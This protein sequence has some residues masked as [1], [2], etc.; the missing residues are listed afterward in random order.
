MY[1]T[2][3]DELKNYYKI[4]ADITANETSSKRVYTAVSENSYNP[5]I[6]K[7]IDKK[8]AQIYQ[9]IKTH[10]HR[11]I[12]NVYSVMECE[13]DNIYIAL[14][15]A[16]IN[17]DIKGSA[18]LTNYIKQHGIMDSETAIRLSLMLCEALSHIHSLGFIHRD[19]K[20]DNIMLQKHS[21][22]SMSVKLIDFGVSHEKEDISSC[23]KPKTSIEDAGT[24]GYNPYDKKIT[25]RFDVF[26]LGC[27][28]NYMLTGHTPDFE[29]YSKDIKLRS[30]IEMSTRDYFIRIKNPE[31]MYHYLKHGYTGLSLISHFGFF[32]AM[33]IYFALAITLILKQL[34]TNAPLSI[35]LTL[36]MCWC[37][38]PVLMLFDP[39]SLRFRIRILHRLTSNNPLFFIILKTIITTVS[40]FIPFIFYIL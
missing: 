1:P 31:D 17:D 22:G 13:K 10:P 37:I 25:P 16:I 23:S 19:L 39:F 12:A 38:I 18:T 34:I 9:T 36:L 20:P 6:V 30:I 3:Y 26:S 28:L 4:T 40:I 29:I 11:Y 2:Y 33:I 35:I 15:E 7:E 8:R 5:I 27:T 21:D 32:A 14:T 24:R